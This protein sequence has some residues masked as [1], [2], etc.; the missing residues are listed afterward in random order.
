MDASRANIQGKGK[1]VIGRLL[2][3]DLVRDARIYVTK[4]AAQRK[5]V[6]LTMKNLR[7]GVWEPESGEAPELAHDSSQTQREDIII[8]EGVTKAI[9]ET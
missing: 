5:S 8:V 3:T 9:P 1:R 6:Y 2:P 4:H 7:I